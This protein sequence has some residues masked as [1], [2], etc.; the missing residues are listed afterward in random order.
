MQKRFPPF[1]LNIPALED[2]LVRNIKS[3]VFRWYRLLMDS[4]VRSYL[5]AKYKGREKLPWNQWKAVEHRHES[6]DNSFVDSDENHDHNS[7]GK[8]YTGCAA[9]KDFKEW[10][11]E[12]EADF[13]KH[14]I[15]LEEEAKKTEE[16]KKAEE[17]FRRLTHFTHEEWLEEKIRKEKEISEKNLELTRHPADAE[18]KERQKKA[19]RKFE[20]WLLQKAEEELKEEEKL[21]KATEKRYEELKNNEVFNVLQQICFLILAADA[22]FLFLLENL[23]VFLIANIS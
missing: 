20:E 10:L 18:K 4:Q 19:E 6:N 16:M 22:C 17:N 5:L 13:H 23:I 8:H 14:Q 11:A 1:R 15:R 2:K 21:R 3:P 9:G 7:A 12:K